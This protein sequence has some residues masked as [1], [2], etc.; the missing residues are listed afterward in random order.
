MATDAVSNVKG[1][2]Q[3]AVP[4]L[5]V[6]GCAVTLPFGDTGTTTFMSACLGT[7]ASTWAVCVARLSPLLHNWHRYWLCAALY[8]GWAEP[9]KHCLQ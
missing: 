1:R 3:L 4:L 5:T 8:A 7:S 6:R 2:P 9:G